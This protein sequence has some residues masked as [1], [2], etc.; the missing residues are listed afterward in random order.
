MLA[1][2]STGGPVSLYEPI[3]G[4]APDIAGQ[5]VANP[6]AAILSI[7]MMLR[8]SFKLHAE[9]ACVERAVSQVLDNGHRTRDLV[10]SSQKSISTSEMG[11]FV[12]QAAK[13]SASQGVAS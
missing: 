9:A 11:S 10:R 2:A 4:S 6:L 7:A 12:V 8:Y 3:H 13:E 1:S 5:G